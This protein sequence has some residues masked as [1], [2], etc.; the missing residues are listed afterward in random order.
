[1]HSIPRVNFFAPLFI[2][3]GMAAPPAK[4]VKRFTEYEQDLIKRPVRDADED[5]KNVERQIEKVEGEIATVEQK[6]ESIEGKFAAAR[7]D[8]KKGKALNPGCTSLQEYANWLEGEKQQLRDEKQQLR[9]EKQQLRDEKRQLRDK[10]KQLRTE[11]TE[12]LH[13]NQWV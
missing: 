12:W 7:E 2:E 6:I 8:W 1:M 10:E 9:D 3:S 13:R 5:V 11:K 4:V